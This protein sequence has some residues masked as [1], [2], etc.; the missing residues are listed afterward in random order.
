MQQVASCVS[1]LPNFVEAVCANDWQKAQ[2]RQQALATIESE[3]DELKQQIRLQMPNNLFMPVSRGDLLQLVSEQDSLAN[4]AKDV[5]GIILGRHLA[6]PEA[7]QESYKGFV[8]A[9]VVATHKA[10]T[11][12]DELD[13]LLETGFRGAEVRM[14]KKLILELDQLER[15]TDEIQVGVRHDLFAIESTLNP[16]DAIFLYQVIYKTGSIADCAQKV[17]HRLQLLIAN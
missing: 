8:N 17:G 9:C 16:I 12:I 1:C 14:V 15:E 11:A 4:I 5:A 6:F 3:A 10:K 7:I 13:D 2:E